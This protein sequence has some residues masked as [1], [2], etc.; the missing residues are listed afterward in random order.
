[1]NEIMFVVDTS[2]TGAEIWSLE[3]EPL[4]ERPSL[5]AS[6]AFFVRVLEMAISVS[7]VCVKECLYIVNG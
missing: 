2:S 4:R 7:V 3:T 5:F 6:G 1:M